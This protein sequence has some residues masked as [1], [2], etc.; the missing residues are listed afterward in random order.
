M[1]VF[2]RADETDLTD[3]L[4]VQPGQSTVGNSRG[5]M[6]VPVNPSL[7][8][9]R[10]FR[11]GAHGAARASRRGPPANLMKVQAALLCSIIRVLPFWLIAICRGFIASESSRT[12]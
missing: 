2:G 9:N 1:R 8:V 11:E 6:A 3:I 10:Y 5:C 4:I 12:N 7:V